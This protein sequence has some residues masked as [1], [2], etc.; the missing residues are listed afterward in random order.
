MPLSSKQNA[1]DVV[2]TCHIKFIIYYVVRLTAMNYEFYA[3][4]EISFHLSAAIHSFI[5]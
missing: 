2:K 3:V 5:F 4:V 1:S